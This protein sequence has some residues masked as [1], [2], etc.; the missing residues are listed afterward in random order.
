MGFEKMNIE[1]AK[2][3]NRLRK[4]IQEQKAF[5]AEQRNDLKIELA[6]YKRF[7]KI[8]CDLDY[9]SHALDY[10]ISNEAVSAKYENPASEYA[11]LT[12]FLDQLKNDATRPKQEAFVKVFGKIDEYRLLTKSDKQQIMVATIDSV[13]YIAYP[14]TFTKYRELLQSEVELVIEGTPIYVHDNQVIITD[15]YTRYS[16]APGSLP[17][18]S[19]LLDEKTGLFMKLDSDNTVS[20]TADTDAAENYQYGFTVEDVNKRLLTQI[21]AL[22]DINT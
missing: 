17:F 4:T 16:R 19:C 1:L 10:L 9:T 7:F 12:V 21:E 22:N 11:F 15:V 18:H 2:E 6:D 20:W 13:E 3:N 14:E 5:V 8:M